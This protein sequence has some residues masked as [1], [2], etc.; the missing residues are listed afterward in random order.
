[1]TTMTVWPVVYGGNAA[2]QSGIWFQ[3]DRYNMAGRENRSHIYT[4]QIPARG[5]LLVNRKKKG[6]GSSSVW[7]LVPFPDPFFAPTERHFR[8]AIPLTGKKGWEYTY[9]RDVGQFGRTASVGQA[10][11][12]DSRVEP[13]AVIGSDAVELFVDIAFDATGHLLGVNSRVW[14][15]A[16]NYAVPQDPNESVDVLPGSFGSPVEYRLH[17]F[18]DPASLYNDPVTA[19]SSIDSKYIAFPL[20]RGKVLG[21]EVLD[22]YKPGNP[23]DYMLLDALGTTAQVTLQFTSRTTAQIYTSAGSFYYPSN[24]DGKRRQ[25]SPE[26]YV[27]KAAESGYV[28]DHVENYTREVEERYTPALATRKNFFTGNY[29]LPSYTREVLRL[30][31]P[32]NLNGPAVGPVDIE[33]RADYSGEDPKFVGVDAEGR[34]QYMRESYAVEFYSKIVGYMYGSDGTSATGT[35]RYKKHAKAEI[36]GLELVTAEDEVNATATYHLAG[37]SHI[38]YASSSETRH[39]SYSIHEIELLVYVHQ[40]ATYTHASEKMKTPDEVIRSPAT[41]APVFHERRVVIQCKGVQLFIDAPLPKDEADPY[42]SVRTYPGL[43]LIAALG[44]VEVDGYEIKT[45]DWSGTAY[46]DA[47]PLYPYVG[48][49]LSI[50]G[51]RYSGSTG[52]FVHIHGLSSFAIAISHC[53][54]PETGGVCLH[55]SIP[56]EAAATARQTYY[57]LYDDEAGLREMPAKMQDAILGSLQLPP[58]TWP[59]TDHMVQI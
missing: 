45:P 7:A 38:A 26:V 44:D 34:G 2:L 39:I 20:L 47:D 5:K 25:Y 22:Y 11:G 24:D 31:Y 48:T 1:M 3:T 10:A 6:G 57:F 52:G 46:G 53:F 8:P 21:D 56:R 54:V 33:V 37:G 49:V 19:R 12:T 55:I 27:F 32:S 50:G 18:N 30:I 35:G 4:A 16:F 28:F 42:R 58:T 51:K 41:N 23:F 43:G 13:T 36:F 17:T 40:K 15:G 9:L 59:P 14:K 29:D